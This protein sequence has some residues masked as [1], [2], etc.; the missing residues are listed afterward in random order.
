MLGHTLLETSAT[1]RFSVQRVD[2]K[3]RLTSEGRSTHQRRVVRP[4][5]LD[6]HCRRNTPAPSTSTTWWYRWPSEKRSEYKLKTLTEFLLY[7]YRL[8]ENLWRSTMM[9]PAD[10]AKTWRRRH[11][12]WANVIQL[13]TKE[14]KG[15]QID[16]DEMLNLL[17]CLS[18]RGPLSY[19]LLFIDYQE[20]LTLKK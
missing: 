18:N 13:C 7:Y 4:E 5:R 11:T 17:C 1:L 3:P 6:K 2:N 10:Y 15:C 12:I 8:I 19:L 9:G 20:V 14:L 16:V